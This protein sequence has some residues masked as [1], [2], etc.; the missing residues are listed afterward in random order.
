MLTRPSGRSTGR[1]TFGNDEVDLGFL[2]PSP[3]PDMLGRLGQYEVMEVLGHG[4]FGIVLRAF[5]DDC[6]GSSR[7]RC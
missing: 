3:K 5:D 6:V 7:S 2:Q 4:G 1:K